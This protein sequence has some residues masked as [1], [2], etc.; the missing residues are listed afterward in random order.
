M[1]GVIQPVEQPEGG[2]LQDIGNRPDQASC[3]VAMQADG[4]P[5]EYLYFRHD[6]TILA[7][8]TRIKAVC[9]GVLDLLLPPL[10][11]RCGEAV[12]QPGQLCAG[13]FQLL[14]F[15]AEPLCRRCGVPFA[16]AAQAG[17]ARLCDSCIRSAPPWREARAALLYDE[18]AKS[19][20]LP[21]KHDD[22]GDLVAVLGVHM[23]RAGA[24]L[25]AR[26]DVL[27]PVPLHRRRLLHRRF[28]QA[29]ILAHD[30]G[31]RARLP[32]LADGLQRPHATGALGYATA[33]ERAEVL[34]DAILVRPERRGRIASLRVLLIDD[35]LTSGATARACAHALLDAG[36]LNV[37]VLVASRVPHPRR[38]DEERTATEPTVDDEDD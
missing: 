3:P 20:I 15:I 11:A 10:C 30:L 27:V 21:L 31:R 26:A 24:A 4:A 7:G 23:H 18:A 35:V 5:V 8:M 6:R 34:R 1:R 13:C 22:R 17:A 25:L 9:R 36:A 28:N 16:T 2:L 38:S 12:G 32:V 19:L 33:R 14:N 37:D 29:A